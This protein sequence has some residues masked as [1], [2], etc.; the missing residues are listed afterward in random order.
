MK[1]IW[2][3]IITILIIAPL[4]IYVWQNDSAINK[5]A[6]PLRQQIEVIQF[7]IDIFTPGTVAAY[8]GNPFHSYEINPDPVKQ[9]EKMI[10]DLNDLKAKLNKLEADLFFNLNAP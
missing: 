10:R 6:A 3:L 9:K 1:T 4:S 2:S 5:K 8:P 7:E